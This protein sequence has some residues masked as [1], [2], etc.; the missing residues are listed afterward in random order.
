MKKQFVEVD[1]K[2]VELDVFLA[3]KN[4][5]VEGSLYLNGCTGLTALPEG[6]TV[7]GSLDLNGCTGLTALPE[8]LTVGGSL[9]SST[10]GSWRPWGRPP[11]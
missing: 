7:G 10:G 3:T 6:L 1:G 2:K 9:D 5:K 8:G 4:L 11:R